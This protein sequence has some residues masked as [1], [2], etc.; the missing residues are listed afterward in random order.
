M[1]WPMGKRIVPHFLR[2]NVKCCCG[3]L[4]FG[5]NWFHLV[6][7]LLFDSP[8]LP[9]WHKQY[10]TSARKSAN[11]GRYN[12]F[13]VVFHNIFCTLTNYLSWPYQLNDKIN[14]YTTFWFSSGRAN[15][16]NCTHCSS[17][18]WVGARKSSAVSG[19][20]RMPSTDDWERLA[21]NS[22]VLQKDHTGNTISCVD[23]NFIISFNFKKIIIKSNAVHFII[24]KRCRSRSGRWIHNLGIILWKTICWCWCG[25]FRM[26]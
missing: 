4:L 24:F 8:E 14:A 15:E 5:L 17:R 2:W 22:V 10:A 6:R 23:N 1:H 26:G 9:I 16:W 12:F 21:N 7:T 19:L 25:D 13:G 18:R 11:F 3:S 20:T